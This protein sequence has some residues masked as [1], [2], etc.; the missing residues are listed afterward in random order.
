MAG[1]N[2]DADFGQD[3]TTESE[4]NEVP[5]NFPPQGERPSSATWDNRSYALADDSHPHVTPQKTRPSTPSQAESENITPNYLEEAKQVTERE[6]NS[7]SA[8]LCG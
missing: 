7:L 2:A 8:R 1:A 4:E 3:E 5:T 6:R